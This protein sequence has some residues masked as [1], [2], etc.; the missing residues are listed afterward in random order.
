MALRK[1][2]IPTSAKETCLLCR[3]PLQ[4]ECATQFDEEDWKLIRAPTSDDGKNTHTHLAMADLIHKL[5]VIYRCD[6]GLMSTSIDEAVDHID[7]EETQQRAHEGDQRRREETTS[8]RRDCQSR[9]SAAEA[10]SCSGATQTDTRAEPRTRAT[11]R[12]REANRRSQEAHTTTSTAQACSSSSACSS[13]EASQRRRSA[14]EEASG[15]R[16]EAVRDASGSERVR[17]VWL[18]W[19]RL[20]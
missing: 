14:F 10:C 3:L 5:S 19:R 4:S 15:A 2:K 18:L 8:D 9:D 6:C 20:H 12:T 7:Y 16:Q 1:V 17:Y 13:P 11:S